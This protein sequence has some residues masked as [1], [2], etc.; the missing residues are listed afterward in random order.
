M[1]GAPYIETIKHDDD[2]KIPI[3][4][5]LRFKTVTTTDTPQ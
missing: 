2:G 1:V 3:E 4:F 5:K